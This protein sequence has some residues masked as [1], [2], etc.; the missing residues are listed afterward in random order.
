MIISNSQTQRLTL[1]FI[2]SNIMSLINQHQFN[3]IEPLSLYNAYCERIE[4]ISISYFL[5]GLDWLYI[6]GL[7][8]SNEFGDIILCK[9]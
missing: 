6:S 8:E 7:A 9:S 5:F 4:Y 1:F 3:S 2:G